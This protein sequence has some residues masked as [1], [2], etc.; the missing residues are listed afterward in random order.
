MIEWMIK[1]WILSRL[2]NVLRGVKDD[3]KVN[4]WR[5]KIK[6]ITMFLLDVQEAVEDNELSD[7]EIKK[8]LDGCAKLFD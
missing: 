8:L 1:K 6:E 2:N 4:Y 3:D 5:K 7:E